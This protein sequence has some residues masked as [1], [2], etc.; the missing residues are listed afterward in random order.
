MK[1]IYL[2]IAAAA[3]VLA[4][5]S[6]APPAAAASFSFGWDGPWFGFQHE[7][8][9]TRR[10]WRGRDR[11][12]IV[13]WGVN[14]RFRV[15]PMHIARCEARYRSYDPLSDTFVGYDGRR[16]RCRL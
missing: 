6:I 2:T 9:L 5:L 3:T 7:R 13:P 8:S 12:R 1:K 15:G 4:S 10:H 11:V 14:V 16:H